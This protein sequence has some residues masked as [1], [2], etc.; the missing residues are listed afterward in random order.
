MPEALA[1]LLPLPAASL[2][3]LYY[4]LGRSASSFDQAVVTDSLWES[5]HDS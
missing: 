4:V 3:F 5:S 2:A 1:A